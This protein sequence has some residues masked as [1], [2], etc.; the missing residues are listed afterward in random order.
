MTNPHTISSKIRET[1]K[2]LTRHVWY[3]IC[4]PRQEGLPVLGVWWAGLGQV[5]IGEGLGGA[6]GRG[7][8]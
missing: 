7:N 2:K 4:S 1:T 3:K 5:G 8:S 6:R